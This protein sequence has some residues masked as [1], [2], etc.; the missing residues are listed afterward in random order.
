MGWGTVMSWCAE[1]RCIALRAALGYD[2]HHRVPAATTVCCPDFGFGFVVI[3]SMVFAVGNGGGDGN[4]VCELVV[5]VVTYYI[6][7]M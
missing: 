1:K 4:G 2:N 5:I 7:S 3:L 6:I